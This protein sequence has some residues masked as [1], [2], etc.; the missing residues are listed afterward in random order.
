MGVQTAQDVFE[1]SIQCA[2][3]QTDPLEFLAELVELARADQAPVESARARLRSVAL[4]ASTQREGMRA[5]G[6]VD[7]AL[8]LAQRPFVRGTRGRW[9]DNL[10]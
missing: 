7:E 10:A 8:R 9:G 1:M 6:L 2:L 3:G 5:L 4:G